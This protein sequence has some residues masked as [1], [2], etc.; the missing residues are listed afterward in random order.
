[1]TDDCHVH[2]LSPCVPGSHEF[3]TY[4]DW[5]GRGSKRV[6][7]CSK[8]TSEVRFFYC[9]RCGYTRE[10]EPTDHD[11]RIEE[12]TCAALAEFVEGLRIANAAAA[13]AARGGF[14]P[15]EQ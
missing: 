14:E 12:L 13:L 1:M 6:E 7:T 8:S 11:R 5:P 4:K 3:V 2:P 9:K 10:A 15:P